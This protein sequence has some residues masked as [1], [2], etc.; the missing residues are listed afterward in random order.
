M[1]RVFGGLLMVVIMSSFVFAAGSEIAT[2][3]VVDVSEKEV[4]NYVPSECFLESYLGYFVLAFIALVLGYFVLKGKK[5]SRKK[6]SKKKTSH[7][8]KK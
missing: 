8:K 6:V 4:V 5:V 3:F 2:N 1:K 7:R